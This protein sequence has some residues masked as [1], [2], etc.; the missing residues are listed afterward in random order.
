LLDRGYSKERYYGAGV[1]QHGPEESW[2]E[3]ARFVAHH[4]ID[5]F[6]Y[7]EIRNNPDALMIKDEDIADNTKEWR[8]AYF[9][10]E[11]RAYLEDKYTKA[12]DLLHG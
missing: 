4:G 3:W 1:F 6:Y 9:T 10:D 5:E 11:K 12:M 2:P 7:W 8:L